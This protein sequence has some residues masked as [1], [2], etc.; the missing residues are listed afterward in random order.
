MEDKITIFTSAHE[1][2]VPQIA[3]ENKYATSQAFRFLTFRCQPS[4]PIVKRGG[5]KEEAKEGIL[6]KIQI[7]AAPACKLVLL[8]L[9]S[10]C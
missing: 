10:I 2:F 3:S 1:K 7:D 5:R 8:I 6:R 4:T 9:A